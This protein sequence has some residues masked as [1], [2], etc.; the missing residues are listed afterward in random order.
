M[1]PEGIWP[2]LSREWCYYGSVHPFVIVGMRLWRQSLGKG[3]KL[4]IKTSLNLPFGEIGFFSI[5]MKIKLFHLNHILFFFCEWRKVSFSVSTWSV[6]FIKSL[7][8]NY[9]MAHL[10]FLIIQFDGRAH[11]F[12]SALTISF[13]WGP[14]VHNSRPY[15][16][17]SSTHQPAYAIHSSSSFLIL[18]LFFS[19]VNTRR[20]IFYRH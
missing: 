17:S 5:F 9:A 4:S 8:I 18:I 19:N 11:S 7:S 12:H 14:L 3:L 13:S 6:I 10:W 20:T 2:R 15:F 16:R 1:G